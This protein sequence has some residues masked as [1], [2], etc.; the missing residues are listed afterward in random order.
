MV[1]QPIASIPIDTADAEA[2]RILEEMMS[3]EKAPEP[4]MLTAAQV[5][6]KVIAY[7][8]GEGEN[9]PAPQVLKILSSAGYSVIYDNRTGQASL[10]NNN[11]MPTQLKKRRD[12]GSLVFTTR[13]PNVTPIAVERHCCMLHPTDPNRSYYDALGLPTCRKANL[14]SPFQVK[15]HMQRRHKVEWSTLEDERERREKEEDRTYQRAVVDMAK[16]AMG[17]KA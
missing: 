13:R 6:G 4:G 8:G 12:D 7:D 9:I 3:L 2:S 11:M 17:A 1:A 16:V 14:V 10:T 15:R 5:I